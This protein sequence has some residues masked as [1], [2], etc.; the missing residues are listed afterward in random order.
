MVRHVFRVDTLGIECYQLGLDN[1]EALESGAWWFY[2]KLGFRPHHP[3]VNAIVRRELAAIRRNPRHR[4]SIATL[5]ELASAEMYLH[6]GRERDDVVGLISRE[7]IG[8]SISRYLADRF[9][10][11]RER[12]ERVCA[13][14]V[15]EILEVGSL[16]DLSPGERLAWRRWSPLVRIL[17]RLERWS[18]GSRRA[19]AEIIRAKGGP[20]EADFVA[21]FD[22][23]RTL[24]RAILELA[25]TDE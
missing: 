19:L 18:A 3:Y 20:C 4:S 2:Y 8:L 5:K 14:E 9:G 24:R 1:K 13:A 10:A 7:A 15:A 21:R 23:H 12:G 16:S 6:L 17:P 22:R 25:A 11:D